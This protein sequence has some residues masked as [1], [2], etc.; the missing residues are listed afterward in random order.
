MAIKH[1]TFSIPHTTANYMAIRN[2]NLPSVRLIDAEYIIDKKHLIFKQTT[3]RYLQHTLTEIVGGNNPQGPLL[4]IDDAMA[5]LML[6]TTEHKQF[7]IKSF[8]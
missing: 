5:Y 4:T 6:D 7:F 3:N 1:T 8:K 2:L